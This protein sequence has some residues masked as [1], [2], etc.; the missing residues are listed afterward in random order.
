[1]HILI[2]VLSSWLAVALKFSASLCCYLFSLLWVCINYRCVWSVTSSISTISTL[3]PSQTVCFTCIVQKICFFKAVIVSSSCLQIFS[4]IKESKI[5]ALLLSSWQ[6]YIRTL[7]ISFSN[8]SF[9]DPD[10]ASKSLTTMSPRHSLSSYASPS[11]FAI[12]IWSLEW[13]EKT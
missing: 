7:N 9:F 3:L 4:S 2:G 1:M 11:Y 5:D 6:V 8:S 10:W 12:Y 13:L